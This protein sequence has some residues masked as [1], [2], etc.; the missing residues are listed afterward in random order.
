VA[1]SI[2]GLGTS[3]CCGCGKKKKL[4]N[5][6]EYYLAMRKKEILPFATTWMDLEGIMLSEASQTENNKY[7]LTSHIW[8]LKKPN[9]Q[10]QN[11]IVVARG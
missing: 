8:N 2:P 3:A 1:S 6:Y 5:L 11:R 10:K 7:H 9:S 4:K